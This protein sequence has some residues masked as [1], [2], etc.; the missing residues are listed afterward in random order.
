MKYICNFQY[1]VILFLMMSCVGQSVEQRENSSHHLQVTEVQEGE[2]SK[3]APPG[4][5]HK[6]TIP[7]EILVKFKDGTDEKTIQAIQKEL[8]LETI[9]IVSKPNL[10]L[11]KILDGSSVKRVMKRLRNYKEVMYSEPN[12]VVTI[13]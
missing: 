13:Y 10:Y 2:Q 8:H 1:L 5:E 6:D 11:M 12:Y 4:M 9:R 7:G 3:L